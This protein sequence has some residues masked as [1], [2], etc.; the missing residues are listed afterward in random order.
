MAFFVGRF[1]E[2]SLN[3]KSKTQAVLMLFFRRWIEA[4]VWL[5]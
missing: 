4:G 2:I 1:S 5:L 3:T